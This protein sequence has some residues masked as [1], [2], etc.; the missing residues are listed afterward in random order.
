MADGD[1]GKAISVRAGTRL[2][3]TLTLLSVFVRTGQLTP[4]EAR[5]SSITSALLGVGMQTATSSLLA[6]CSM[7]LE[8][9]TEQVFARLDIA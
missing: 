8:Q 9:Q 3:T 1:V 6:H 4:E 2:V 7:S 5:S